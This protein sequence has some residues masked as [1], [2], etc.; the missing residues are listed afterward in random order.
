MGLR[1]SHV[2]KLMGETNFELLF[3]V[4]KASKDLIFNKI[5]LRVERLVH[6]IQLKSVP[7]GGL[8]G[9]DGPLVFM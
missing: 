7:L 6:F 5:F 2:K 9:S 1:R 3:Y 4:N 8:S